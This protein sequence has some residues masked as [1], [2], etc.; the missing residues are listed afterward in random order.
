MMSVAGPLPCCFRS[1]QRG[2]AAIEFAL[3][4][5]VFVVL[6][7]GTV[8]IGHAFYVANSLQ[9]AVE[10]TTRQLMLDRNFTETQF[11]DELRTLAS[12][13]SNVQFQVAYASAVYGE[14]PVTEVTTTVSYPVSIPLIA[15]LT[16]NYTIETHA[17][18]PISG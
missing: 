1:D 3:I 13:L 4:V 9:W 12:S 2:I 5:P 10:R 7:I 8:T 6:L 18:R 16:M 15:P 17:A 11:E 14:I